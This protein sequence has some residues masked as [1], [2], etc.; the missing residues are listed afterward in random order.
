MTETEKAYREGYRDARR[1]AV[2]EI[3]AYGRRVLVARM[4][5]DRIAEHVSDTLEHNLITWRTDKK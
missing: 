3:H 1:D 4:F 2:T 5:A